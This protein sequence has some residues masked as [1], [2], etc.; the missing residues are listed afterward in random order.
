MEQDL[1]E[2]LNKVENPKELTGCLTRKIAGGTW[3]T[4]QANEYPKT[5]S[6]GIA[7]AMVKCVCKH[8]RVQTQVVPE[9]ALELLFLKCLQTPEVFGADFV[10]SSCT[11]AQIHNAVEGTT[12]H[13]VNRLLGLHFQ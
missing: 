5:M 4:A 9:E 2:E 10:D 3:K 7:A 1:P 6:V 11:S 8:Q 13:S 12:N